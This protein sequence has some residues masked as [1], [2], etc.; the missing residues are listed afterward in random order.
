[1][2]EYIF[3][4]NC[5]IQAHR[6]RY[7]V[8]IAQSFWKK[9]KELADSDTIA[10]I[11]RVYDELF[12]NDDALTDWISSNLPTSFFEDTSDEEVLTNYREVVSWA[13]S[14]S[15]QY[16]PQAINDFLE[17]E[18][19]DAWLV[20]YGM[21]KGS[22]IVTYEVSAPESKS[23]IKLPDACNQFGVTWLNPIEM[24]RELGESF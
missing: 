12:E 14:M 7:P 16:V 11:D 18:N 5:F 3:D 22:T 4:S 19:A 23:I 2:A 15:D 10:S 8:D 6:E 20:A 24:F 1:M 17:Y 9:I 13:S 21:T